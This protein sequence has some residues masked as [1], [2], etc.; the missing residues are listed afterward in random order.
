MEGGG[1]IDNAAIQHKERKRDRERE[2]EREEEG[3]GE[4]LIQ[5]MAHHK[6]PKHRRSDEQRV[7]SE[8]ITWQVV[9][10]KR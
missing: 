7:G 10:E 9:H 6:V 5:C 1:K 4:V 2:K 3:E 8:A